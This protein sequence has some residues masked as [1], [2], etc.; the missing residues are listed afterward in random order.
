MN[1]KPHIGNIVLVVD[2]NPIDPRVRLLLGLKPRETS[3][4][5]RR[6]RRIVGCNCFVPPGG[7]V[8]PSDRSLVHSAQRELREET[9]LKLAL[10]SF[11]KVGF[12]EGYFTSHGNKDWGS[13]EL[14]WV[15]S[16]YRVI[17]P[18]WLIDSVICGQGFIRIKWF[19]ISRL[20]F[21]R[22]I[23]SDVL[24]LPRLL[25]GWQL[26]IKFLYGHEV[27]KPL[28]YDITPDFFS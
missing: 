25:K 10:N 13:A 9:G 24:W 2:R 11:R 26:H 20:P 6:K 17:V 4:D 18:E 21:S 14:K 5:R 3:A 8:E 16:I 28:D 7:A 15:A 27:G 19:S 12:L 23:N 1:T 22:M